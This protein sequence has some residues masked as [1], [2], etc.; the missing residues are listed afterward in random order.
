M[1]NA[2]RFEIDEA[3]EMAIS[4]TIFLGRSFIF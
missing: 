1:N 2:Y 4:I 3:C